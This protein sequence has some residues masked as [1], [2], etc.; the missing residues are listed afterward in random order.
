[1]F[2]SRKHYDD[3][4]LEWAKNHEEARVLAQQ[5]TAMQ[6]TLDWMRVQLNQAQAERSHF[7]HLYSGVKMPAPEIERASASHERVS[8]ALNG[9][10]NFEDVGDEAARAL[11]IGWDESGVLTHK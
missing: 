3:L 1:M 2:I 10:P 11:G 7:M 6:T 8:D 9:L 4:R 5:N